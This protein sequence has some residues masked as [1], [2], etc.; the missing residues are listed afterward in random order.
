[1]STMTTEAEVAPAEHLTYRI[2]APDEYEQVAELLTATKLS[3]PG[4]AA[5]PYVAV[6]ESGEVV[7]AFFKTLCFHAEP[8]VAREG[9]GF[10][11]SRLAGLIK[12]SFVELADELGATVTVY[13]TAQDTPTARAAAEKNGM[14]RVDGVLY[15]IKIEPTKIAEVEETV[16]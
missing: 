8:L 16:Q 6:D 10:S 3:W 12:E 11:V 5:T 4:P 14:T 15:Q 2:A 7:A 13:T 1:M 9:S